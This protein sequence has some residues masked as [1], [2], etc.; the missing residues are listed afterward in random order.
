M[1]ED[2]R[3]NAFMAVLLH[4]KSGC[5]LMM[6]SLYSS[7]TSLRSITACCKIPSKDK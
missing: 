3:I 7:P 1:E 2:C 4:G 5:W 6:R